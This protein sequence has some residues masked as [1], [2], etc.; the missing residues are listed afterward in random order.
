MFII[1]HLREL[2]YFDCLALGT[3]SDL[4]KQEE[5][6]GEGITA[7]FPWNFSQNG[8]VAYKNGKLVA[9]QTIA[10]YIGEDNVKRMVNW[11]LD[12]LSKLD[13]PIK[14]CMYAGDWNVN[15]R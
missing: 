9:V 5:Q 11:T 12:Y 4:P 10:N 6:L 15:Y 13:I 2:N 7:M 1:A 3:G 14:V 8:L